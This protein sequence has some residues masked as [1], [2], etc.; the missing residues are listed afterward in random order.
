MTAPILLHAADALAD[1][2]FN[3]AAPHSAHPIKCPMS[4][5]RTQARD[6]VD[7]AHN[8]AVAL[9]PLENSIGQ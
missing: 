4:T 3:L 1:C 5:Q 6:G 7:N 9:D 2:D 8:R